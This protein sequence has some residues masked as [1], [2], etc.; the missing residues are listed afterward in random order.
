MTSTKISGLAVDTEYVFSLVL[1]TSA[2]TY[3]SEKLVVRTHKMTDLHGITVTPGIMAPQLRESLDKTIESIGAKIIETIRIDTTHFVCTEGR[4]PAFEKAREMNIPVVL[5]D[6]VKGC[7]REGRLV[8]VRG[9]YLDANPKDRQIASRPLT[10]R[11]ENGPQA[12]GRPRS[13]T[14][15]NKARNEERPGIER[16]E[17]PTTKVT[18]PTP[19]R[20]HHAESES[21]E[22]L[23]RDQ[24]AARPSEVESKASTEDYADEGHE[25]IPPTDPKDDPEDDHE[26]ERTSAASTPE[27][28]EPMVADTNGDTPKPSTESNTAESSDPEP[29]EA[30]SEGGGSK[31]KTGEGENFDE[32]TL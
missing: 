27:V 14:P 15:E 2:G 1:R 30:R 4:G 20:R 25:S 17:T 8:G 28:A 26:D 29:P 11:S 24:D 31:P 6:W 18:P 23:A 7:E 3:S 22:D 9:Y 21:E 13:D 12:Q 19:E 10:S 5:P 16:M 32:V